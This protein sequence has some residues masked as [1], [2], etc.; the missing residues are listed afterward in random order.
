MCICCSSYEYAQ[1]PACDVFNLMSGFMF[2][3][4]GMTIET[5]VQVWLDIVIREGTAINLNRNAYNAT[6]ASVASTYAPNVD[7]I[8]YDEQWRADAYEFCRV[9]GVGTCSL[10]TVNSYGSQVFDKSL[11]EYLFLINDGACADQF[12]IPPAAFTKLMESPPTPIVEDYFE[13]K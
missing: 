11:S 1:G 2:F 3:D 9:P 13:C 8:M 5:A 4:N 12:M 7:P 10:F 6:W